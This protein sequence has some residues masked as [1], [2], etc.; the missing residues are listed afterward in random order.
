MSLKI[1]QLWVPFI[2]CQCFWGYAII[3]KILSLTDNLSD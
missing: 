3:F 1:E 2:N